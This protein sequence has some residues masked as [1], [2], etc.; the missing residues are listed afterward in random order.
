MAYI[1]EW[2]KQE[3]DTNYNLNMLCVCLG[4]R[5]TEI[6]V[7]SLKEAKGKIRNKSE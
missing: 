4:E 7:L 6:N 3:K 5:Q 2:P 1:K